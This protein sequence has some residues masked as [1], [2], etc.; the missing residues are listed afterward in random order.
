MSIDPNNVSDVRISASYIKHRWI[1][2]Y[3]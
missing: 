2:W 1:W 3:R